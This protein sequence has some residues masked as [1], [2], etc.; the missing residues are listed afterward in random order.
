MILFT[1]LIIGLIAALVVGGLSIVI[2]GGLTMIVFGDIIICALILY[3]IV[4]RIIK[5]KRK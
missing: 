1:L 3:F 4:K 5:R 2:E